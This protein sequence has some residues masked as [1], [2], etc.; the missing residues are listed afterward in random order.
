MRIT[1]Y[2]RVKRLL[3]LHYETRKSDAVLGAYILR[4]MGAIEQ[5]E[6]ER[7]SGLLKMLG[8][9]FGRTRREVVISELEKGNDL[10]DPETEKKRRKLET[11]ERNFFGKSK[12]LRP[13][14]NF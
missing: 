4:S 5:E 7:I 12:K 14:K 8:T 11:E 1:K 3:T 9:E 2:E 6:I 13:Y 10:R